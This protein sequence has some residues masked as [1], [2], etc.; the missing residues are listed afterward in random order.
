MKLQLNKKWNAT[1]KGFDQLYKELVPNSG[2]P[3]TFLGL[4]CHAI[5]L[6]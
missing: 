3:T 1:L 5:Q 6:L 4:S 2:W